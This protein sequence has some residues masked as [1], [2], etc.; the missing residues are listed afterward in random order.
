MLRSSWH[1]AALVLAL[2]CLSAVPTTVSAAETPQLDLNQATAEQLTELPGVGEAIA[3]RI[4]EFR[5]KNGPFKRVED[6]LKVKGIGEKSLDKLRP[7]L[8]VGK[9]R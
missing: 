3:N 5:K 4:V 1:L 8:R 6:L 2:A 9:A 7:H